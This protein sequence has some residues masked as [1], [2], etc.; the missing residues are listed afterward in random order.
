M[1]HLLSP[2]RYLAV[3]CWGTDFKDEGI[4]FGFML[5]QHWFIF[6]AKARVYQVHFCIAT[7]SLVFNTPGE[8]ASDSLVSWR[9]DSRPFKTRS[10]NGK[11]PSLPTTEFPHFTLHALVQAVLLANLQ[12]LG[13]PAAYIGYHR[14]RISLRGMD[15]TTKHFICY[16][17]NMKTIWPLSLRSGVMWRIL[18]GG[19]TTDVTHSQDAN[20]TVL[21]LVVIAI[22]CSPYDLMIRNRNIGT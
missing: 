12:K 2:L 13:A 22:Q 19:S 11:R 20:I 5:F 14:T 10:T 3:E 16:Q 18:P 6:S 7:F 8:Y 1:R 21:S 4:F 17:A 9:A 15:R